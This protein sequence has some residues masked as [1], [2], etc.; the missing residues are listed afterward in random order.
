MDVKL[1]GVH[2]VKAKRPDGTEAV[3]CYAW[4]GGP[5]MQSREGT[6]AFIQEFARLTKARPK[7]AA[8][9]TL[10][11]LANQYVKSGDYHKLKA[12]TRRDYE[13]ILH[14][15]HTEFGS[16]PLAAVNAR[17]AR[18]MFV[19]WRD[20]MKDTPRSADLHLS[21]LARVLSWGFDRE[22]IL[23]N[24]LE[25]V[26]RLHKGSR[27][28][29][30]W[31]PTQ[32]RTIL[33][34]RRTPIVNVVKMALWTMQR[35]GDLLAMPTVAY[36][37]DKLWIIQAKTG[38][39]I[40]ITPAE[41]IVPILEEAKNA[42]RLRALVNSHGNQ[43]TS[44]GFRASWRATMKE[45]GITGVTFHD[46]RGTAIS[47]AHAMGVDIERIAEISGHSKKECESIIRKHYLAGS[48]IIAAIRAGTAQD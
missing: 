17:G 33:S 28:D 47:Y 27:K 11:W 21:V 32:L 2:R 1:V 10:G 37:D 16:L 12:S 42:K 5:R 13:R 4:R 20:T 24:P 14:A 9:E 26:K 8:N 31:T 22:D 15:I 36:S 25:R 29:K 6:R 46:L 35:Q 39:R 40:Q 30:I 34:N 19:E 38:A 7:K 43:W 3:Y 48:D 45:L 44:C 18:K 41:E 23:R